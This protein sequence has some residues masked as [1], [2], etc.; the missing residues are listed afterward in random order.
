MKKKVYLL[1]VLLLSSSL[2]CTGIGSVMSLSYSP[3]IVILRSLLFVCSSIT[4]EVL[5]SLTNCAVHRPPPPAYH[6]V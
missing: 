4:D 3:P 5:L 6:N 2:S 1:P